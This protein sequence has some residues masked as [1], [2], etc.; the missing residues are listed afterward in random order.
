MLV[1]TIFAVL[2][3]FILQDAFAQET[4]AHTKLR[5]HSVNQ[6]GLL[7]GE[8]KGAFHLQSVNGFENKSWFA[9]IGV[10][11][12][13]YRYKSIPLFLDLKKYF[14][15][16]KNRFFIYADGGVHFVWIKNEEAYLKEKYTPGFYSN[17]GL[18]YKAGLRNGTA[19]ILSAGY[20]YKK[21]NLE[22]EQN[23]CGIVG[24]CTIYQNK[25][26]YD[27]NRLLIQ[28]GWIF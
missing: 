21:V 7:Q 3:F 14:G 17:T 15:K 10:G 23:F 5:F 6:A 9:G 19:I 25:Y 28:F 13:Y 4:S 2:S 18:G 27:L 8:S 24:P 11:L 1:R 12:D 22:Q 26:A 16:T 20:S